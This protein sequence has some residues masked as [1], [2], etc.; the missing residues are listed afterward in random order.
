M[1]HTPHRQRIGILG[2]TFDP[3]H[4]AHLLIAEHAREALQLDQV[5]FVPAARAPHKQHLP[6]SDA[7]HRWEMVRLA[8]GGNAFFAADDRELRRGG[9]SYTVDTLAE[10]H[11]QRPE[12]DLFFLMGA[13]SL[14]ELHTWRTPHRI[15]EL[16]FVAVVARGG[17]PLPDLRLLQPYL[18]GGRSEDLQQHLVTMPQ[19]E[20]S[21]TQLRQRVA[22]GKSIRYQVPPAVEAYIH[23]QGMYRPEP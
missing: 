8:I 18:P 1:S 3:I 15:C 11:A 19:M 14:A 13:D 20:I 4:L 12:D 6:A 10:L 9:T 7:K 22:Q 16:A 21:S 5:R 17:R 2:G 23:A